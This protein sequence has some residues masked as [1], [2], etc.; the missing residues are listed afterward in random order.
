MSLTQ[1]HH[2]FVGVE[3]SGINTFL[4]ALFTARPH[5]LHYGSSAFVPT[6]T[7]NATN[8]PA[9]PFP[10]VPGGIQYAVGFTI[11]VIDLFPPNAGSGSPIPPAINQFGLKTTVRLTLGCSTFSTSATN[12]RGGQMQPIFADLDVWARGELVPH[13][14]GPGTGFVSLEVLDIRIPAI[15]PK[16]FQAIIDCLIR[17]M[18]NGALAGVQLPFKAMSLGAF[19]LILEQGPEIDNNQVEVWGDI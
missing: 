4:T 7:A 2:V 14:F 3:E 1:T 10:G 13:F 16:A 11:P 17:M 9:I 12:D 6:S 18:L 5:Y 15:Q 8:I 19:Q